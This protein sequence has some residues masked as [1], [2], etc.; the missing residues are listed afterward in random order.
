LGAVTGITAL[1]TLMIGLS[2]FE[3]T[4]DYIVTEISAQVQVEIS[5]DKT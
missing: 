3:P 1:P 4:I 5:A 2:T